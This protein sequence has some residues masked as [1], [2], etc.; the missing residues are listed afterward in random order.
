MTTTTPIELRLEI[1]TT[2]KPRRGPERS[3]TMPQTTPAPVRMTAR[4]RGR[5]ACGRAVQPGA[6][7]DY[8]A[9]SKA[10]VGCAGC[11]GSAAA[12]ARAALRGGV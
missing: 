2:H 6:E 11:R 5:C 8:S 9:A 10:V 4:Y 12:T 3:P 7:I 1:F